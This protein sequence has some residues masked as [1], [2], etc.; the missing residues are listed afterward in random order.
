MT[1]ALPLGFF[2]FDNLIRN[3]VPF[4]LLHSPLDVESL[5]GKM[6]FMEKQHL[7]NFSIE[8]SEFSLPT[9]EPLLKER[10]A[11]KDSPLVVLDQDGQSALR[12]ATELAQAGYLNV[13]YVLGGFK[14]LLAEKE[15]V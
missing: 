9:L 8:F 1:P 6:D 15:S 14:E 10:H 4:F 11:Q 13:Y 12:F 2:Q 7:R 5:Y 3:R